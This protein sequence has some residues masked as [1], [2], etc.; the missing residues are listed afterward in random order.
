LNPPTLV[1]TTVTNSKVKKC[2]SGVSNNC[3]VWNQRTGQGIFPKINRA[4]IVLFSSVIQVRIDQGLAV[5]IRCPM[6]S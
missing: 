5:K 2:Y 4:V 6:R 3:T 1:Q